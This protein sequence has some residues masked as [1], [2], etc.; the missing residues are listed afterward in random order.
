MFKEAVKPL[1]IIWLLC[2]FGTA[3]L[4]LAPGR[5][6]PAMLTRTVGF[7][8][9]L[10]GAYVSLI[11]FLF[12]FFAGAISHRF[13][14]VGLMWISSILAG[15]G[16]FMLSQANSPVTGLLAAT[17]WAAG[18]CFMWPTMLGVASER[19]PRGG[20]LLIGLMG[21]AGQ[22]SILFFVPF[23]GKIYDDTLS[24][25]L[26]AGKTQ[27][28]AE[29]MAGPV[30]FQRMAWIAVVL[31][32]VFGA[33]WLRDKAAGGYKAEQIIADPSQA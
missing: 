27:S 30:A 3:A 14:P 15:I 4:E 10:L 18:V 26:A 21:T 16:L 31:F 7:S 1:F 19:F 8:G 28:A 12:R 32:V 20:A 17:I 2:M 11:M 33:I 22:L 23:M 25:A 29:A 24:A 13:S 9:L 6:V 5:W